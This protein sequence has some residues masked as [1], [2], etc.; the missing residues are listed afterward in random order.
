[1]RIHLIAIGGS[2]MHNLALALQ[3]N[4]HTVTGSDDEIYNPAKDRLEAKG[5]LPKKMGWDPARINEGIDAI[6]LGMHARKD[7]PELLKAQSLGIPIFSYPAFL[8]EAAKTKQRVVI[9]GSH[10]KTTTT[11]MVL[12]VLKYLACDFD[13]LVGAIIEGF[14]NMVRISTA[15]L[16]VLEGDEYLSSP[17]DLRP[18][19]MHYQPHLAV[20][21]GIAWDHINVFPTFAGYVQQFEQFIETIQPGGKLFYYKN[22]KSLQQ[23]LAGRSFDFDLIP[24]E[25]FPYELKNQQTFVKSEALGLVPLSIFGQHNLENLRA[26]FLICQELGIAEDQFFEAIQTF[27]GAAKRLQILAETKSAIAF[28]DFAHA[29]SKLKATVKA[30]KAQYP[31][32]S[33]V[34]CMELHTF[35]SLN[36]SFFPEYRNSMDGADVAVVFYSEHTLKMK[37]LP[38]FTKAEVKAAFN[39]PNLVVLTDKKELFALLEKQDW[40]N[41]NLLLMS[42]GTFGGSDLTALGQLLEK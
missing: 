3:Y 26:A 4:H 31:Q 37:K 35:S 41:Q 8:Y 18:K 5:L 38:P 17:I 19:I 24:Y 11:S 9:A 2:A 34:A 12:H 14:D 6:I 16:M 40:S 27:K 10:G 20:I 23:I 42:S 32:R 29:P 39:H 13:Y 15:D 22:D 33:L 36:K 30:V 28:Q 21:T 25:A 1:M 7:N